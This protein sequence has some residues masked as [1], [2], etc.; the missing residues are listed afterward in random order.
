MV[1]EAFEGARQRRAFPMD[2]PINT[3]QP[4]Q[5]RLCGITHITNCVRWYSI[6]TVQLTHLL[7]RLSSSGRLVRFL[8]LL[9]LP[10]LLLLLLLF[11]R[12]DGKEVDGDEEVHLISTLVLVT[13]RKGQERKGLAHH[14]VSHNTWSEQEGVVYS[15]WLSPN[16]LHSFILQTQVY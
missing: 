15:T 8:F 14:L 10:L 16:P 11:R 1:F 12:L 6:H 7:L 13:M 4:S 3:V 5:Q 9:L 2:G